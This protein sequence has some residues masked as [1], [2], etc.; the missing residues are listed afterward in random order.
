MTIWGI[1]NEQECIKQDM[2]R[3]NNQIQSIKLTRK[4]FSELSIIK[5]L[6]G[7]DAWDDFTSK[8]WDCRSDII[9]LL[10][11]DKTTSR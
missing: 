1:E 6:A 9:A 3:L 8:L 7:I 4:S 2:R 11:G 5:N 10:N